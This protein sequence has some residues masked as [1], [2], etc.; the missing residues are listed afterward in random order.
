MV[1]VTENWYTSGPKRDIRVSRDAASA[2]EG[3]PFLEPRWYCTDRYQKS[4]DRSI[5]APPT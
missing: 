2:G 4:L 3:P 5:E 1:L